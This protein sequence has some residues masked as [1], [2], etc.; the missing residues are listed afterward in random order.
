[1]ILNNIDKYLE[2]GKI[3]SSENVN[4]STSSGKSTLLWENELEIGPEIMNYEITVE[5]FHKY[6]YIYMEN[7]FYDDDTKKWKVSGVGTSFI[8]TQILIENRDISHGISN[9]E[10]LRYVEKNKLSINMTKSTLH[11]VK[12]KIYGIE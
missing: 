3:D 1:M 8:P 5:D 11:R 12:M 9:S 6:K 2:N 7:Y 4:T 10:C